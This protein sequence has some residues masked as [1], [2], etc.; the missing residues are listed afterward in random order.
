MM[1][2]RVPGAEVLG[3][4]QS[5]NELTNYYDTYFEFRPY[6]VVHHLKQSGDTSNK[7]HKDG[8]FFGYK[9]FMTPYALIVWSNMESTEVLD[10]N[11]ILTFPPSAVLLI[12]NKRC[13]HRTPTYIS[14]G[15]E[16]ARA[17]DVKIRKVKRGTVS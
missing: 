5:L 13:K 17:W 9:K 8:R 14:E 16:F 10:G 3:F 7:W 11:K 4:A 12:R 2:R 15:R 6:S 1:G